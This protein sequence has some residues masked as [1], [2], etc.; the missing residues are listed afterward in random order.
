ML[1]DNMKPWTVYHSQTTLPLPKKGDAPKANSDETEERNGFGNALFLITPNQ[2]ASADIL[3]N[4]DRIGYASS[5]YRAFTSDG[6]YNAKIGK[7]N[8]VK[9]EASSVKAFYTS[10][11]GIKLR[12]VPETSRKAI[13]STRKNI[14][15]DLGRWMELY[16]SHCLMSSPK[17]ICERFAKFTADRLGDS[18]YEGYKK[19]L[20]VDICQWMNPQAGSYSKSC[21]V[22]NKRLLTNPI[23]ILSYT[24]YHY[25]ELLYPYKDID[26]YLVSF[27][28]E[29]PASCMKVPLNELTKEKFPQWKSRIAKFKEIKISADEEEEEISVEEVKAEQVAAIK[30][31]IYQKLRRGLL[32]TPEDGASVE[33]GFPEG[34]A[35]AIFDITQEI[36]DLET[37]DEDASSSS[38]DDFEQEIYDELK[39]FF[40][41]NPAAADMPT[42]EIIEKVTPRVQKRVASR[43]MPDRSDTEIEK[44]ARL[45]RDQQEVVKPFDPKDVR[46]KQIDVT[47]LS[48]YIDSTN[49][50]IK[51]SKFINF[52][53]DYVAKKYED[54]IDNA[55]A[56]LSQADYPIFVTGREVLDTSDVMNIKQ[57]RVYH[58]EDAKGNKMTL[59]FDVPVIIDDKYV[60]INGSKKIIGH[61]FILKPLVKTA[62]DTVQ[63]VSWYNKVFMYRVGQEDSLSNKVRV[64]LQKNAK[65]YSV[66]PGATLM[67]NRAYETS[68]D[69]DTLSKF[70]YSFKIGNMLFITEIDELVKQYESMRGIPKDA[71][72]NYE[73]AS[74]IPVAINMDTKS[75]VTIPAGESYTNFVFDTFSEQ[76]KT[77]ISRIKRKPRL[78]YVEAKMNGVRFPIV[79]FMGFCVGF[80]ELARRAGVNYELLEKDDKK[81]LRQYDSNKWSVIEFEDKYLVWDHSD[82]SVALLMNPLMRAGMEIFSFSELE[83]KDTWRYL[84]NKYKPK[85]DMALDNYKDFLM[86]PASKE[87]LADFGYPTN[88]IDLLIVAVRMLADEKYKI[89]SDMGNMRVRSAEVIA[90]L[91][92]TTCTDAYRDYRRTAY[93]KKPIPIRFPPD[94]IIK[95]L[96]DGKTTNLLE[97]ASSLNPVLELEK[98]RAI[99]YKGLRGIQMDRALTLPRRGYN[100]SMLGVCGVSTSPD[101]NVGI[102][103]QLTLEPNITSTRGYINPGSKKDVDKL[104][105]TNLFTPA[106][107]L[108]PLGVQHDDPDRTS[109]NCLYLMS[110]LNLV[111]CWKLSLG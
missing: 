38:E 84:L 61:Q 9:M 64:H 43:F 95:K 51:S 45:T 3:S 19:T 99:T 62:P 91:V 94:L 53:H 16:F 35:G 85:L 50:N 89:E 97:E 106:E 105:S 46:S 49:P 31:E 24:A 82:L 90:N 68:L 29:G 81:A 36:A 25:P 80:E 101:S 5:M 42:A 26:L 88:L 66:V 60:F 63:L 78:F 52:D 67:K 72:T 6:R 71:H 73:G 77:A 79:L 83:D 17:I 54:D 37:V 110:T 27:M 32:G 96:Q 76:E 59:K 11:K 57:T 58:L 87:I 70:F 93:K 22:M 21:I 86:D 8:I 109:I 104:V 98:G 10:H 102:V 14:I 74:E 108:T 2:N 65:Q 41:G 107:L 4:Q 13:L 44:I 34:D 75:L 48:S 23:A 55:V 15:V 1:Y 39:S 30:K 47:D 12:Y 111:N 103:R 69:F 56:A 40:D 92:Y 20:F 18:D 28:H 7:K 33:P 100:E